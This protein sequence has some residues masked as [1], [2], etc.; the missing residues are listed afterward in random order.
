MII[1]WVARLKNFFIDLFILFLNILQQIPSYSL[2]MG[3]GNIPSSGGQ[4]VPHS[5]QYFPFRQSA[6]IPQYSKASFPSPQSHIVQF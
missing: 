6:A 4:L 3:V 2:P 1:L 5:Q